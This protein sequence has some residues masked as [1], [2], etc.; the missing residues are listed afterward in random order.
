MTHNKLIFQLFTL[1]TL[2]ALSCKGSTPGNTGNY[3][4]KKQG[5]TKNSYTVSKNGTGQYKT[6]QEAFNALPCFSRDTF[7]IFVKNGTYKEKLV[8][9]PVQCVV[10][11]KGESRENTI[12][13]YDDYSGRIVA[14]DTLTTHNSYTF[15]VM[16]DNFEAE[17]LTIE[18]SAGRIG[19]AVAIEIKSDKVTFKNCK[20]LGNQ[21]TFYANSDGRVY[22]KGCYI[23]GTVDFI[24]GK[25]IV[26]FDSCIIHIKK[27]AYITA[28]STPEGCHYGFVFL[29]CRL[30]AD[31]GVR[32]VYLGR[33]WRSFARTVYINCNLGSHIL[34]EGWN[35]WSKPE[36]EKTAYYAE[37]K[38]TGPGA[39]SISQ[40][41]NWS[42]QLTSDEAK[43]Y[44]LKNIFSKKA[45]NINF[46]DNWMP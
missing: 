13:S 19:Q 25:S 45:S 11:L 21:D 39:T 34:P 15:R 38:S 46:S 36:K 42:H 44:T 6:V 30:T 31:T 16:A 12:I 10:K 26:V 18:N 4:P 22:M 8:L 32:K 43:T 2:A 24:F 7:V 9:P 20:F 33:P 29:N 28:A 1:A 23:E 37:Y 40:R 35:N 41:A 3:L 5:N 17:G 14:G 27:D